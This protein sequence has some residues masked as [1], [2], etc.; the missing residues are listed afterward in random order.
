MDQELNIKRVRPTT[1]ALFEG[2]LGALIGLALALT[3]FFMSAGTPATATVTDLVLRSLTVGFGSGILTLLLTPLAY[4]VC[5]WVLGFVHG[6]VFNAV[7]RF[8]GGIVLTAPQ[9]ADA[10]EATDSTSRQSPLSRRAVTFGE[11]I[12][13]SDVRRRR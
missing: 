12:G 9:G 5:G 13:P 3:V 7:A 10:A 6:I 8:Q 11:R 1:L 4:F 2:L